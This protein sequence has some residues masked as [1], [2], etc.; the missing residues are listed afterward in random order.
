[1]VR[2]AVRITGDE[3]G[4]A[5]RITGKVDPRVTDD[6][7]ARP[8]EGVAVS[9][10]FQRQANPHA[11]ST[12]AGTFA[13]NLGRSA[14][15]VGSRQRGG[16]PVIEATEAGT[17]IT[18]SA[19]GR[20]VRVTGDESGACRPISGSQ[21][22]APARLETACGGQGGGT[23]PAAHLGADRPDPVTASKVTVSATWGG[24]RVTGL[25]VEHNRRVTGDAPGTC[26]ALTG[27][28]YQGP[29]T[30]EGACATAAAKSATA[31]RILARASLPVTGDTPAP[32]QSVSGL[33]RGAARDIT[34]T[35]YAREDAAVA[36]HA[37]PVGALDA[38]FSIRSPQRAA[39][40][41]A[42]HAAQL[43]QD[44]PLAAG[45]DAGRITGSFAVGGG[46][47]TGNFEFNARP[48]SP[49]AADRPPA[50]VKLSGEGSCT[51][52]AITGDSWSA[53]T[54][55]T[56][57]EGPF[58]AERNPTERGPKAKPFAGATTFKIQAPQ[59]ESR[60]LV[61]GMSGYSSKTGARITLS[62]GAQS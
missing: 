42:Q 54:R 32:S 41:A 19:I 30:I 56:G 62:G 49:A 36:P 44:R 38:K 16:A 57:T 2:S 48:R 53:Q 1:L 59:D 21:Y 55:V 34:G 28:Q 12:L 20:S 13:G 7:T 26:A 33:N 14:R 43:A 5:A 6:L 60:Q 35:P 46:K 37:D 45:N 47:V 15:Q 50:H 31:R 25:D 10:Q 18:G 8:G 39:Q 4:E 22:L 58:A 23:A 40:R 51:G 52:R 3:R 29:G 61:T 9:V 24:Q 11:K 17:V 27:S